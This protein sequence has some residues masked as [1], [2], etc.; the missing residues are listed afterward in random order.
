MFSTHSHRNWIEHFRDS[1]TTFTAP[2]Y[3]TITA[4]AACSSSMRRHEAEDEHWPYPTRVET[5]RHTG[6]RSSCTS[7]DVLATTELTELTS[8]V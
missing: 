3:V 7:T 8:G 5:D 1:S 6:W 2:V 4:Q